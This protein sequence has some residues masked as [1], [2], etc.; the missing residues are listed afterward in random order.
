M[1]FAEGKYLAMSFTRIAEAREVGALRRLLAK[2]GLVHVVAVETIAVAE[3][4][5]MSAV[6]WSILTGAV[7]NPERLAGRE[8]S[9][10]RGTR[11]A[12]AFT[13]AFGLGWIEVNCAALKQL[14]LWPVPGDDALLHKSEKERLIFLDRSAEI[15][16]EL[17]AF[18][19][20][21]AIGRAG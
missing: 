15:A 21:M 17:V 19:R 7:A 20:D 10:R 6:P 3:I 5:L 4:V 13:V 8:R 12:I 18:K 14:K 9:V 11:A 1:S 2:I 16:P